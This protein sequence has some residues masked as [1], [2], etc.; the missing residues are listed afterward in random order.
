MLAYVDEW[1]RACC[2]VVCSAWDEM[3][4]ERDSAGD[5]AV[6]VV[7]VALV[8]AAALDD[9]AAAVAVEAARK[10][11]RYSSEESA[12]ATI[13]LSSASFTLPDG[14]RWTVGGKGYSRSVS[15]CASADGGRWAV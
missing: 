7:A 4:A 1:D 15:C 12:H 5:E 2:V 10:K 11:A 6:V 14:N 13:V 8:L 3:E 9:V